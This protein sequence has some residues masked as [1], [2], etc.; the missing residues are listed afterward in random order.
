MFAICLYN[1]KAV[2]FV[3]T[4]YKVSERW[5]KK[6][7]KF[8]LILQQLRKFYILAIWVWLPFYRFVLWVGAQVTCINAKSILFD[9][10]HKFCGILTENKL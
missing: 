5:V 2:F 1:S 3:V 8:Q 6:E 9:D 4:I 10:D 7:V